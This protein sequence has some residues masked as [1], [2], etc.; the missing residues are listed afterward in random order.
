MA[1]AVLGLA[2]AGKIAPDPTIDMILVDARDVLVEQIG[3][4]GF[5]PQHLW[6]GGDAYLFYSAY[7]LRALAELTP[8][9]DIDLS[10]SIDGADLAVSGESLAQR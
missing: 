1:L 7:A 9:A 8:V 10:S 4:F 6:Y 2:A 5:V 3:S